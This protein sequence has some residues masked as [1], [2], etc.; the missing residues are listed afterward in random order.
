ML[1]KYWEN[2][3]ALKC[4]SFNFA[5]EYFQFYSS[6]QVRFQ[7]KQKFICMETEIQKL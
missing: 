5:L 6:D 3:I 2:L 4:L 1:I 7:L